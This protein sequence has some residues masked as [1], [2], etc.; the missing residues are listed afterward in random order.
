LFIYYDYEQH[1]CY[2][3]IILLLLL[4]IIVIINYC[5]YNY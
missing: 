3:I 5:S 2:I 1:D 4:F